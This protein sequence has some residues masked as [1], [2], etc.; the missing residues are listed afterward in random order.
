MKT[1]E[2]CVH[3]PLKY[4]PNIWTIDQMII[5]SAYSPSTLMFSA[6]Y[7][8]KKDKTLA[9]KFKLMSKNKLLITN[10]HIFL[11][12][13]QNTFSFFFLKKLI[14]LFNKEAANWSSDKDLH[15]YKRFIFQINAALLNFIF[16]KNYEKLYQGF[17]KNIKQDN[18]FQ[19]WS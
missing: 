8:V 17:H 7:W 2:W 6:N 19:Y 15:C 5:L 13:L 10:L 3:S 11:I 18:C 1:R 9:I 14:L 12:I 4:K 16:I